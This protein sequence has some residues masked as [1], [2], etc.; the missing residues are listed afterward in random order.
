MFII[1]KREMSNKNIRILL[2]L[3]IAQ[4]IKKNLSKS[5]FNFLKILFFKQPLYTR[6]IK[7]FKDHY[8]NAIVNSMDY[9]FFEQ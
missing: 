5:D 1:N 3:D 7:C 4:L 6:A 8:F 2:L 9:S